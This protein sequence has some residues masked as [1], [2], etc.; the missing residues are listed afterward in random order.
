LPFLLPTKNL[1]AFGDG[2]AVTTDDAALAERLRLLRNYGARV[3]YQSELAG[4]NSRLDELQAAA[5]RVKLRHLDEWNERRRRHAEAY[6]GLLAGARCVLPV[7]PAGLRS[8]W[9]LFVVQLEDRDAVQAA[10]REEGVGT[11]VHYPRP[12]YRQQALKALGIAPGALPVADRLA[13]SVLSLPLHPQLA[14]E[15]VARC[16]A[17]LRETLARL[18]S[19]ALAT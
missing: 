2:G 13:D 8:C 3:R 19:P 1:G 12:A 16:A 18:A 17:A 10:L 6:R 5:L 4:T 11:L 14:P 9:H 15:Q 7:E